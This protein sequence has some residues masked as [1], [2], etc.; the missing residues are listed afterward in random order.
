MTQETK[1]IKEIFGEPISVYTSEQAEDDGFLVRV[2]GS[3]H[4]NFLTDGVYTKCIEP[5]IIKDIEGHILRGFSVKA[6]MKKLVSRIETVIY[7]KVQE[8]KAVADDWFYSVEASG[9]KFFVAQ[10][11]TGM[12]TVMFPSE[13]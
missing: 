3:K 8:D 11:E 13:Y 1:D 4:I 6:L 7:Q 9:W 5:F 2:A 12:F 10:N